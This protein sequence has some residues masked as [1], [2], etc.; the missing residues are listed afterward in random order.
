MTEQNQP[1]NTHQPEGAPQADD[2]GQPDGF[3]Q[4]GTTPQPESAGLP[5]AGVPAPETAAAPET[6]APPADPYT[7]QPLPEQPDYGQ[8]APGQQ[9]PYGA[10]AAGQGQPGYGQQQPYGQPAPGYGRPAYAAAPVN[11][12]D[13]KLWS[14]LAHLGGILFHFLPSLIIFLVFKDRS[15]LIAANAKEALNFQITLAIAEIIASL[16]LFVFIGAILLPLVGIAALVFCI[17][18]GV[19]ASKGGVVYR[20]PVA[21]RL[22]K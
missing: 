3:G 10:P 7:A 20:Y 21:L 16:L 6:P 1:E 18:G 17:L 5:D 9:A 14:V 8:P 12:S 13:E 22:I 15:A 4:Q 11:P 2:F 19:A